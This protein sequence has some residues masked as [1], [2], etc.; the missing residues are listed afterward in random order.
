MSVPCPT[1]SNP[2]ELARYAD[3]TGVC[4]IGVA[5][6]VPAEGEATSTIIIVESSTVP[7]GSVTFDSAV[8][9]P[10]GSGVGV[11]ASNVTVASGMIAEDEGSSLTDAT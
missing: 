11:T 6:A 5:R 4:A 3:S 9:V 10:G 8:Y 1:I 2:P 7:D